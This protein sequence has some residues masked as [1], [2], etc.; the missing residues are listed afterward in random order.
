MLEVSGWPVTRA[1]PRP[2]TRSCHVLLVGVGIGANAAIFT[3][4]NAVLMRNLPVAD[5]ATLV[6]PGNTDDC[7][8]NGGGIAENDS[9]SLFSTNTWEQLRKNLPEFEELAAMESGFSYRPVTVRRNG[10][11]DTPRSVMGEFVS[12]NY[13]RTFGLRAAAGRL[14]A[15]SDDT[16]GAPMVAVLSYGV[17]RCVAAWRPGFVIRG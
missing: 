11:Q 2:D 3:L 7:C 10:T 6:R 12:G 1:Q 4:V 8:V 15:D 9:Y 14:F 13:F 17:R 16:A 5:P